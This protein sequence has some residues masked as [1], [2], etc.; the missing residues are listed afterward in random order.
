MPLEVSGDVAEA[1]IAGALA[2][3]AVW[4]WG[5]GRQRGRMAVAGVAA[6]VA[7]LAWHAYLRVSDAASLDVDNPMLLGLS[8]EDAGT[9]VLTFLL[10]ALPLGL[11][12]ERREP[13]SKVV[14]AAAIAALVATILDLFV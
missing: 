13:A 12:T 14:A 5:W 9:G 2:A 4:A 1:L 7:W 10:A 3:G 6:L 8:G 11:V